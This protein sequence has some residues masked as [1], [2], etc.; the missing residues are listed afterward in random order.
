MTPKDFNNNRI[1]LMMDFY[2][3]LMANAFLSNSIDNTI[4]YYDLFYRPVREMGGFCIFAGLRQLV[5]SI[6]ALKFSDQDISYLKSLGFPQKF[7]DYLIHFEFECDILAVPE[8]T[9][10][11]PGEPILTVKGPVIQAKMLESILISSI[12]QHTLV[13]TKANRIARAAQGRKVVEFGSKRAHSLREALYS[14]RAAY[15][16]GC[17]ATTCIDA[18]RQFGIPKFGSMSHSFIQM[19]DSE[20]EAFSAFA[21]EYPDE[22]VLLIDTYDTLNSGIKNAIEAFNN[23]VLPRGFRPKGVRID[24][25][26]LAYISKKVRRILNEAG[27]PDC[28]II[29]SNALDEH[30]IKDMLQHGA[31]VDTFMVGS[32]LVS[33]PYAPVLPSVYKLVAIEKEGKIIPKIKLSENVS[34]IT[35]PYPKTLWRLFDRENGKAI[36]DLISLWDETISEDE[37]YELFDPDF[38]WKRKIVDNFVARKLLEP[39][40]RQG[41]LVYVFPNIESVRSYCAEQVD[42]LWEEVLRFEFPHNYYVDLSQKLWDEKNRL[43]EENRKR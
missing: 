19:F 32:R 23:E 27:F 16:G 9:P 1:P 24:S 31:R 7:L 15:I 8:G 43:I 26:D 40:Y 20:L 42:S 38:T 34:K 18:S 12:G 3:L 10:I 22:C 2:E 17:T 35:T 37:P 28:D 11:F 21:K 36:A 5:D 41:K 6:S 14:A 25:G 13:A 33:F 29:V 4:A 30:I 39:I